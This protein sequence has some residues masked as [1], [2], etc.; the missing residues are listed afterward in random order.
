MT[1]KQFN[2]IVLLEEADLHKSWIPLS[3]WKLTICID[4]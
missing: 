3:E 2:V 1:D 4:I